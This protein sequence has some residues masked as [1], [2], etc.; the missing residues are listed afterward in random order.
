LPECNW[1]L[2]HEEKRDRDSLDNIF[3]T[4]ISMAHTHFLTVFRQ[5][6]QL[7]VRKVRNEKS[8][9]TSTATT[10]KWRISIIIISAID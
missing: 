8:V 2:F 4:F 10:R 9:C 1:I 5:L 3:H 7:A 6:D